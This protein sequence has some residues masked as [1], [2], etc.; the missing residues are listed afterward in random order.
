MDDM[1]EQNIKHI[2]VQ[3]QEVQMCVHRGAEGCGFV[4]YQTVYSLGGEHVIP[5]I[6]S[7]GA[8]E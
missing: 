7:G 2:T 3:L 1:Q 5:G 4:F 6:A 8:V